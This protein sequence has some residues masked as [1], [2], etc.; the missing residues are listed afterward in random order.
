MKLLLMLLMACTPDNMLTYEKIVEKEIYIEV[1]SEAEI[2]VEEIIVIEDTAI[3]LTDIWVDSFNQP[4]ALDGVD[5][6]WVIDPSGSMNNDQPN[7]ITGITDMMANLPI[8]GWR[9]MILPTDYRMV[10][11]MTDFPIVPG[12]TVT[13]VEDMYNR[14][15]TGAFEAGFD[16]VYEYIMFNPYAGTWLRHDA[17]MLIVFVSDE[18]EQSNMYFSDHYDYMFWQKAYRA[19]SFIASIINL[20]PAD[21]DCNPIDINTGYRYMDATNFFSGQVIDICSEDWSAGVNDASEQVTPYEWYDLTHTP[22]DS[23]YIFVFVNGELYGDWHHV[24]AENR[25]YFDIIPPA[26]SLVEIAYNY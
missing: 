25:V 18:E 16:A 22:L 6:F 26:N 5:I 20:A 2:V 19:N 13:D 7:I 8:A 21:S 23:N 9:L 14:N 24:D 3:D 1:E 15:V 10:G 11:T 4:A 17:A 12:D